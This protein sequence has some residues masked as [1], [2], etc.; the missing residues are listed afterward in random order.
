MSSHWEGFGLAAVE[1]MA[2]GKPVLASE[3][4]GLAD[5]VRYHEL[6]FPPD[7]DKDLAHKIEWLVSNEEQRAY[8]GRM[9]CE[10]AQRFSIEKMVGKYLEFY[11]ELQ[12]G[13]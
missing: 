9:C 6:L 8:W 3:V 7:D 12:P 10:N 1:G 11:R 5:V 2:H 4:S 13:K